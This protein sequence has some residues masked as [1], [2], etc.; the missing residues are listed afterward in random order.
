[1][2][3]V[4]SSPAAQA[5]LGG[6][7]VSRCEPDGTLKSQAVDDLNQALACLQDW[8]A[9]AS[10]KKRKTA[11]LRVWLSNQ[12]CRL[13]S[14]QAIQGVRD[15]TEA[16]ASATATLRALGALDEGWD[17]QVDFGDEGR[18]SGQGLWRLALVESATLDA[19]VR[20][21]GPSLKSV[22]P[23]WSWALKSVASDLRRNRQGDV[24]AAGASHP[25]AQSRQ[26]VYVLDGNALAVSSYGPDGEVEGAQTHWPIDGV[27]GA[28]RLVQRQVL[29]SAVPGKVQCLQLSCP[30]E[31]ADVGKPEDGFAW[32]QWVSRGETF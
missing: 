2:W 17:A 8:H 3:W 13:A 19:L 21:H 15:A 32:V 31:S 7:W 12:L 1:M 9:Q 6:H 18:P 28:R 11:H 27:A 24:D 20:I 30:S 26:T 25:A 4:N 29:G 5:W 23:W 22:R 16:R 14:V 10:A